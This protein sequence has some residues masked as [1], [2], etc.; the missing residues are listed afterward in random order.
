MR[1]LPPW[2]ARIHLAASALL[3]SAV[4]GTRR[5]PADLERGERRPVT[6]DVGEEAKSACAVLKCK[7]G[8][9]RTAF[10]RTP[11][12]GHACHAAGS[13]YLWL[14]FLGCGGVNL[15]REQSNDCESD[16]QDRSN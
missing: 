8:L 3:I 1:W 6:G 16:D 5:G 9:P 2:A 4:R 11:G 14:G 13:P 10:V 7:S 15:Q 12:F